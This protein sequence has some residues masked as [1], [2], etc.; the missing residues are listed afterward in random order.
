MILEINDYLDNFKELQATAKKAEYATQ[1]FNGEHYPGIALAPYISLDRLNKITGL[2]LV[3]SYEP[4]FR[5]YTKTD[6][7]PTFI[8]SDLGMGKYTV[9]LYLNNKKDCYGGTAFWEHKRTGHS[10]ME[11]HMTIDN[12]VDMEKDAGKEQKWI[13]TNLVEM[14]P[15]KLIL[16][17]SAI[18]HSR[19]PKEVNSDRLLY[20]WFLDDKAK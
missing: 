3:K 19:Y 5:K 11:Q 13:Q 16:Y 10:S 20:V 2:N 4:F 6:T 15:N 18:Y 17:G 8:H 12:A 1:E 14:E 7:F 9:I